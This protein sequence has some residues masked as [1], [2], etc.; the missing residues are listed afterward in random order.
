MTDYRKRCYDAFVSTHWKNMH[1]M[2]RGEY[3]LYSKVSRKLF[4]YILPADKSAAILDIG[5]GVGHFLYFLQKEGYSNARGIDRSAQQLGAAKK[6]GIKNLEEADIFDYLSKHPNTFDFAAANDIIEHL[7]KEEAMR[8]LDLIYLS[9]R[10]S[11][12]VIVS[13]FNAA[14]LFGA[15]IVYI[16]FTHE[17][18]FTPE[19]I[20][21]V[22]SVC[23]F[24]DIAVYGEG[25]V[26]RDIR[27]TIRAFL[28]AIVKKLIKVYL[29]IERG[30]GRG[31]WK[32]IEI[33]ESRMFAVGIKKETP[34]H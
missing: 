18:G 22:L 10:P 21:Q 29:L 26:I 3:E 24:G 32:R 7:H 20:S 6:M 14:S 16:D 13:T 8:L 25:P 11:G 28:W 23:G 2:S 1:S 4:K 30:T 12:K 33:F 15:D 34:S 5:C 27:S 17:I 19:S 9:L 31:Y